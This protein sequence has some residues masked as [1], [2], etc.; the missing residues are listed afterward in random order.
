M[1]TL[2]LNL[3]SKSEWIEMFPFGVAMGA[4]QVRPVM[5]FKDKGEKRVLPV[6]LSHMDAGI[7][8][9]QSA[10]SHHVT[11]TASGSPHE[12]SWQ[13]LTELGIVLEKCLFKKVTGHHQYVELHL[14]AK[15]GRKLPVKLQSL[16]ARADD[17]I[18]F[19]LRSGCKFYATVDYIEKSRVL[20]GEMVHIA[21]DRLSQQ[22]NPHKYMN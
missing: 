19:C 9:A 18:S 12:L 10:V 15:S 8:V 14:R 1:T 13:I 3:T 5:I 11:T 22:T 6:W 17:A 2:D 20:E 7:A 21:S 4:N 16:E